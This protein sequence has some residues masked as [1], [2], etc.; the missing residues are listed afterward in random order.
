MD[1]EINLKNYYKKMQKSQ[2][3]SYNINNVYK[4]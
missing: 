2:K 3:F 4:I 1:L